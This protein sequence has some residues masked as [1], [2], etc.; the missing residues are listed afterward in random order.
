MNT[1]PTSLD[2]LHFTHISDIPHTELGR[3]ART[4]SGETVLFWSGSGIETIYSGDELWL[5]IETHYSVYEQWISVII[6]DDP[7]IRTS[8]PDG[9]T[10]LCL[11]RGNSSH[12]RMHVRILKEVQFMHDD[13]DSTLLIHGFYHT[14]ASFSKPVT[15]PLLFEFVGDSITSGTG[16]VGGRQSS[17]YCSMI[18]SAQHAYPRMVADAFHADFRIISQAGWGITCNCEN[19]PRCTLPSIY[20]YTC[21][22]AS[23]ELSSQTTPSAHSPFAFNEHPA[24]VIVIN[25]GTND[26]TAFLAAPWV[27]EDRTEKFALTLTDDNVP[28][29]LSEELIRESVINFLT[30]VRQKN[31]HALL[32]WA[33]GMMNTL[34]S[35]VLRESV[36]RYARENNDS[37]V[38]YIQLPLCSDE[39]I[40]AFEHPNEAGHQ[41]V[42]T[43]LSSVIRAHL[44]E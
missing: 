8:L 2:K 7:V 31:P 18:F 1:T 14:D 44:A 15:R 43:T 33:Y 29:K 12:A 4:Q 37:R 3:N 10:S 34:L 16:A 25:L 39:L 26:A 32:I 11:F 42:A 28:D 23:V 38:Q 40:G 13:S 41:M 20:E 22:L 30:T 24:D 9:R 5:D 36:R 19:D 35:E 27:S 6:N 21:S 17:S